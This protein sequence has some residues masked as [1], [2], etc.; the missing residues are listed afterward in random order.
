MGISMALALLWK[1]IPII[2]QLDHAVLSPT[3]GNLL[4]WNVNLGMIIFVGILSLI[5]TLIRK[6]TMDHDSLKEIKKEQKIL[7]EQMKEF[8]DNPEKLFEL[9]KKQLEF[10]PKTMD[11]TM[12][13]A[14]YT[15]IPMI[16]MFRWFRDYF[17]LNDISVFGINWLLAYFILSIVFMS[18]FK[19]LLKLP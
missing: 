7:K 2:K 17:T 10:I 8:K 15:V 1:K 19:K 18:L 13:P 16:L 5:L 6:Y 12:K 11:I 14:I 4:N 9:Q 3:V